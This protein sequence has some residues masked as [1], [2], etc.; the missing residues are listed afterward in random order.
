MTG[1]E[2]GAEDQDR[3]G[4]EALVDRYWSFSCLLNSGLMM[5]RFGGAVRVGF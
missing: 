3:I 2:V 1:G 5:K 4:T